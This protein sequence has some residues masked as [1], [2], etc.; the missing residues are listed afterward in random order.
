MRKLI[1]SLA[2]LG[3]TALPAA[4]QSKRAASGV[5]WAWEGRPRRRPPTSPTAVGDFNRGWGKVGG[6]GAEA[7]LGGPGYSEGNSIPMAEPKD[8]LLQVHNSYVVTQDE[9]G[10]LIVDQHALHQAARGLAVDRIIE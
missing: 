1:L 9:Q 2:L 5:G 4:A 8:R 6:E 10:L 7:R 3:L